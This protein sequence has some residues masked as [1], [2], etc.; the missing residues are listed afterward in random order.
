[1]LSPVLVTA[2]GDNPKTLSPYPCGCV[3]WPALLPILPHS[4]IPQRRNDSFEISVIHVLLQCFHI[5]LNNTM[6]TGGTL[7]FTFPSVSLCFELGDGSTNSTSPSFSVSES[8][9]H[10]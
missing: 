5:A 10:D 4:L 1:M 7:C 8:V 9:S 6:I 3:E 2:E